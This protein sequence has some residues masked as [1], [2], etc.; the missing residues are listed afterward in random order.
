MISEAIFG[1]RIDEFS[2][3][4][5]INWEHH[6]VHTGEMFSCADYDV[7]VDNA[8]P[9]YW[10]IKIPATVKTHIVISVSLS[11]AG[12]LE[13]Y[14]APT[15]SADGS[16]LTSQNLNDGVSKNIYTKIYK[17]P[18]ISDDGTLLEAERTGGY[19]EK[20]LNIAGKAR[21]NTERIFNKSINYIIKVTPDGDSK[22]AAMYTEFYE[23][24]V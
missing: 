19:D 6:L 17:D 4:V 3:P 16:E 11:A 9:K 8:T 7:T 15:I 13:L 20:K 10:L 21:Q 5:F 24:E 12:L 23:E 22:T 2:T 14:K 1:R 18:T